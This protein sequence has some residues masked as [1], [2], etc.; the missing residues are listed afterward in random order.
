MSL[1]YVNGALVDER[2]ARVSALDHG[3]VVGDGVFE[4]VLLRGGRPFALRRHLERIAR[5]ASGLGIEPPDVVEIRR[6]TDDVVRASGLTEGR[7]RITVT[8]GLGP[9]GSAR[10]DGPRTVVV[11]V[12]PAEEGHPERC[13]VAVP[14]WRRNLPTKHF[15][16]DHLNYRSYGLG[17]GEGI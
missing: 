13:S 10:L 2:D 4:T 16:G 12:A 15:Q 17:T 11:A 7:I 9:L 14:P 5:S 3:F 1:C 6:A 8:D